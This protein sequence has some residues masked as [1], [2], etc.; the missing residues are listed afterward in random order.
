MAPKQKDKRNDSL[1]TSNN[2]HGELRN[3]FRSLLQEELSDI[4]FTIREEVKKSIQEE[5][6]SVLTEELWG[7]S[8]QYRKTTN[9]AYYGI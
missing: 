2:D 7:S 8:P 9:K 4:K 1:S 6:K 3:S 5:I